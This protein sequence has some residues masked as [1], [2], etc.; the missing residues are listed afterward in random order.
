M[1]EKSKKKRR[2][3]GHKRKIK[4][5]LKEKIKVWIKKILIIIFLY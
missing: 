1:I 4:T 2:Q 5:E 3:L